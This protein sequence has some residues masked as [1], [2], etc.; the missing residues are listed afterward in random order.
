VVEEATEVVE[1]PTEVVEGP[2]EVVEHLTETEGDGEMEGYS[3]VSE[4]I[5]ASL[6]DN[7]P[8]NKAAGE[9]RLAKTMGMFK[10]EHLQSILSMPFEDLVENLSQ[11]QPSL[12]TP[13][14]RKYM[15]ELLD[16][17]R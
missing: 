12:R 15:K 2:T 16:K 17:L 13:R 14:A 8:V 6:K 10:R 9:I 1:A 7:K 3:K 4:F 5:S 11:T